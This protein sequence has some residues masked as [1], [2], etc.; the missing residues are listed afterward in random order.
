MEAGG[1]ALTPD[2]RR[3]RGLTH[4]NAAA[5]AGAAGATLHP[6]AASTF[7]KTLRS[8]ALAADDSS[9]NTP[10]STHRERATAAPPAA[11]ARPRLRAGEPHPR[12]RRVSPVSG[13]PDVG[14]APDV[15]REIRLRLDDEHGRP[16]LRVSLWLPADREAAEVAMRALSRVGLE[17]DGG[18][19]RAGPHRLSGALRS[20]AADLDFYASTH[21]GSPEMVRAVGTELFALA[22]E[23]QAEH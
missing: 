14:I 15:S 10:P 22:R 16:R 21:D 2:A 12:A 9:M 7:A 13:Q 11:R 8:G 23:L 19:Y 20:L 18:P 17:V 4:P 6:G 5:L 3:R 1:V